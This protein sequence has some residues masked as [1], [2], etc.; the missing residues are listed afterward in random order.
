MNKT[1]NR[2]KAT[3]GGGGGAGAPA[4]ADI[5]LVLFDYMSRELGPA[6]SEYVREH[7]RRCPECQAAAAEIQATLELVR[8][9]DP[10]QDGAPQRLSEKRRQHIRWAIAHPLMDWVHSHHVIV[11][12]LVALA[13][14]A[15]VFAIMRNRVT[16]EP[17]LP[18]GIP[19]QIGRGDGSEDRPGADGGFGARGA[20]PEPEESRAAEAGSGEGVRP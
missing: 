3:D 2:A 1:Q 9:A 7:L 20:R 12:I 13:V 5:Q 18:P 10:A 14:T 19:V 4:C 16:W 17:E 11:S 6:R 15:L 8:R